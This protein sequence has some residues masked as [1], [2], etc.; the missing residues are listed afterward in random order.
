VQCGHTASYYYVGKNPALA[1][2]TTV[3]FGLNAQQQNAWF[4]HGGGLAVMHKLYADFGV[5]NFPRAIPAP[6]WGAGSSGKSTPWQI[7]KG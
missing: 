4:Y 7:Y 6:K 5:I 3:P 1:F 2:G